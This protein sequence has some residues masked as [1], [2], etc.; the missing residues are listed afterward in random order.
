MRHGLVEEAV[1]LEG[2]LVS[3]VSWCQPLNLAHSASWPPWDQQ[4]GSAT[5]FC[6][7]GLSQHRLRHRTK[8]SRV[9]TSERMSQNNTPFKWLLQ[10][11][12]H[13]TMK[14]APPPIFT[15]FAHVTELPFFWGHLKRGNGCWVCSPVS[16]LALCNLSII[17]RTNFFKYPCLILC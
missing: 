17:Q 14:L 9:E 12:C 3:S 5:P 1:H 6:H 16:V 11:F 15:V 7:D 10:A 8:P 4:R 13:S 2:L